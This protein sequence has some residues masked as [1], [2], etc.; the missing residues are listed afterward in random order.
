MN[1]LKNIRE[2]NKLTK[3][4]LAISVG[5]TERYI[6]FI[7]KGKRTPSLDIAGKIAKTLNSSVDYIF[8]PYKCT[9]ST[10]KICK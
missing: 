3:Q 6:A 9:I 1:R 8:L 7:E 10:E 2:K 4:Q 5:V